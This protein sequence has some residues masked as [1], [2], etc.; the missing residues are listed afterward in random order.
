M[1]AFISPLSI[2]PSET[3]PSSLAVPSSPSR[4][5]L[6]SPAGIASSTLLLT[7]FSIEAISVQRCCESAKWV[8]LSASIVFVFCCIHLSSFDRDEPV[9]PDYV[10]ELLSILAMKTNTTGLGAARMRSNHSSQYLMSNYSPYYFFH[11][12]LCFQCIFIPP[13]WGPCLFFSVPSLSLMC[14]VQCIFIH[15]T[16]QMSHKSPPGGG[17]ALSA[18]QSFVPGA[19]SQSISAQHTSTNHPSTVFFVSISTTT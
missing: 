10:L 12:P 6:H 3:E 13:C 8:K 9:N 16:H 7:P 11:S 17:L 1:K 2:K 4:I 18:T 19:F 5:H 15:L 14:L